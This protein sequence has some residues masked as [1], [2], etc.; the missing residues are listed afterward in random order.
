MI[1]A[2]FW[3]Q[4]GLAIAAFALAWFGLRGRAVDDHPHCRECGYDL[5]GR[6][7]SG[8]VCPECGA[9]LNRRGAVR[10][11]ERRRRWS[12][13]AAAVACVMMAYGIKPVRAIVAWHRLERSVFV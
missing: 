10:F 8:G 6:P 1:W 2:L 5:F 11:G 13:I 9:E 4:I 12:A 7:A 3:L